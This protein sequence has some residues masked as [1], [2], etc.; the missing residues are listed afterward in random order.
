MSSTPSIRVLTGVAATLAIV[1]PA[2]AH[3]FMD[4]TTPATAAE[5]LL[6]GLAH[7][8]IG[9]DHLLFLMAAATLLAAAIR[10]SR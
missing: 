6:S 9:L 3:H 5:G 1:Q 10:N 7:P 8:L 4:G 2:A